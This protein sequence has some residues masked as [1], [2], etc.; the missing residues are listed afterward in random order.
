MSRRKSLLCVSDEPGT[1]DCLCHALLAMGPWASSPITMSFNFFACKM[2]IIVS[3]ILV[4]G[5]D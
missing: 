1:G 5:H 3:Q 4:N 2:G